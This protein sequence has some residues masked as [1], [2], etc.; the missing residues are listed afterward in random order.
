M[1]EW[2]SRI[3]DAAIGLSSEKLLQTVAGYRGVVELNPS[4]L[5]EQGSERRMKIL[6]ISASPRGNRSRT[7]AL[8]REVLAG[9]G[10]CG[11]GTECIDIGS[12]RIE[13][14]DAC[15]ACNETGICHK[16]DDF[17][18]VLEQAR[19]SDGIV[20]GSP[21]YIDNV[22]AQMK[23]F[24]DRSADAIHYQVLGGKFGCSVC[25]TFE[26]GGEEVIRNLDRYLNYLGAFTI[27]G[28]AISMGD[29]AALPE[30]ALVMARERGR[31]LVEAILTKRCDPDQETWIS[32]NREFFSTIVRANR[33]TRPDGYAD[34]VNRGWIRE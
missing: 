12:L 3:P 24:M 14:C 32:S 15:D 17:M 18:E 1:N 28:L 13:C 11:S 10:T 16:E 22:T 6:G 7:L 20:L 19:R 5:A 2:I 9:A 8:V 29:R 23:A 34:W 30:T 31:S 26:S 4:D 21:V 33:G 27:T 25:T